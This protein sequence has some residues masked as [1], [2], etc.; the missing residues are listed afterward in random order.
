MNLFLSYLKDYITI[1]LG[2]NILR[3]EFKSKKLLLL[4]TE[5]KGAHKYKPEVIDAFFDVMSIIDAAS[6]EADLY[7]LKSLHFEKLEGNRGKLGQ[8]SLR[9]NDQFRLI[10]TIKKDKSGKYLL[11]I[12]I[13]D[14]H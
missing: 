14:Y 2:R 7:A 6:S 13:E 3:F 11:I 1:E 4:Y 8:R 12:D 9:L 10:L 5:E